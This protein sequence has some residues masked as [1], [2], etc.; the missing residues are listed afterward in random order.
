MIKILKYKRII[1]ILLAFVM[2]LPVMQSY[3]VRAETETDTDSFITNASSIAII[4]LHFNILIIKNY[5]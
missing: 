4:L 2:A 5:H 1:A 3:S